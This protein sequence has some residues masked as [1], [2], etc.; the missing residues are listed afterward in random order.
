[1]AACTH[2]GL[3]NGQL[4]HRHGILANYVCVLPEIPLVC[5]SDLPTPPEV[6]IK[7]SQAI[8]RL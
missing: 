6:A 4:S 8:R 2:P 1:M 7:N 3:P 5:S